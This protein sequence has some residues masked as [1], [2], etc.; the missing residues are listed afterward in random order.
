M[1]APVLLHHRGAADLELASDGRAVRPFSPASLISLRSGTCSLSGRAPS[2]PRRRR[3]L[4]FLAIMWSRAPWWLSSP[5]PSQVQALSLLAVDFPGLCGHR[6]L[7]CARF[8]PPAP[9]LL[10]VPPSHGV[11]SQR[12]SS[13]QP[14]RISLLS[15]DTAV[16][17]CLACSS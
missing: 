9:F 1:A 2:T 6:L 5:S 7:T 15:L 13:S 10:Q 11:R 12:P 17:S 8:Q 4:P 16:S 14:N 3:L